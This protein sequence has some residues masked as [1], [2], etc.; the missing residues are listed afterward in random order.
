MRNCNIG[1]QYITQNLTQKM[2]FSPRFKYQLLIKKK[3]KKTKLDTRYNLNQR[4]FD[5]ISTTNEVIND[6]IHIRTV[7]TKLKDS[8]TTMTY[9][10]CS[11]LENATSFLQCFPLCTESYNFSFGGCQH[12]FHVKKMNCQR[13]IFRA[14]LPSE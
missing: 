12:F 3:K 13:N 14:I 2:T 6:N 10:Y 5:D 7:T 11:Y 4:D 1:R 8:H 9:I